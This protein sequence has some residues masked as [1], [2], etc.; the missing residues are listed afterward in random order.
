MP[1][2]TCCEMGEER[3]VRKDRSDI[4]SL[5]SDVDPASCYMVPADNDL[6]S[7]CTFEARDDSQQR[8]LPTA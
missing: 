1:K 7:G 3:K 2:P 6:A 4:P 8:G 5:R